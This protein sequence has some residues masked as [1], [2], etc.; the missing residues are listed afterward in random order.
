MLTD[1]QF[2]LMYKTSKIMLTML[3]II[4]FIFVIIDWYPSTWHPL[5]PIVY[6]NAVLD[7]NVVLAGN[8]VSFT[9]YFDKYTTKVGTMTRYLVAKNGN[10]AATITLTTGLADAKINSKLKNVILDIPLTT[11]PGHY[12][13]RWAV[14]YKYY[15]RDIIIWYETPEF[16]VIKDDSVKIHNGK[17]ISLLKTNNTII[18]QNEEIIKILKQNQKDIDVLKQRSFIEKKK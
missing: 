10:K 17:T 13:V 6:H 9:V 2:N 1:N 3:C 5:K 14:V 4:L 11:S 15:W 18:T 7:N 16:T 8:R 12:A